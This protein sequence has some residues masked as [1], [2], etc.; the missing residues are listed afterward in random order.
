MR[1]KLL[2]GEYKN[3][4]EFCD[5]AWL[6]FEN[7]WLY[8][9]R[10]LRIYRMCTKLAQ[11]FGESIDPVLK[12]LGYCCGHQYVYLP[13]VMLCYGKQ[14]CCEIRPYSSY[15]YYN[16]PE[17]L[18]FNL[19][20]HQYTFCTNC[21]HSIK[22]ESIFVG[23]DPTQKLVEI[24][25][26]LFLRTENDIEE[27]E[28]MTNCI[29]CTR[30]WHQICAL[31]LDQIWS[32]GFICNTCIYQYNIKR[33]ENCYI[34]QKLTVTDLSSQ[35]EQRVN[36]YLFDKDCH[37][38]HVTIRV[39]AS[40]DKICKI[41]PQLKKYYPNQM[42][43]DS[44]PYR[45]KAIF[46]FQEIEGIDVVFF[47][48]YV[49]EYD[50]HCPAPNTSRVYISCLDTIHFF[51]PKLYRQDVYHE[52]L[53]LKFL[54]IPYFDGDLWPIIIEETIE[55]FDQE[56][57]R[58]KQEVETSQIIEDDNFNDSFELDD[59]TQI[60]SKRKSANTYENKT[61]KKTKNQVSNSTDLLSIIF[62]T[63]EKNKE[64]FFVIRLH[65]QTISY[66]TVND[67]D[68]LLLCNIMDTPN[69]FLNFVRHKNY[70]FSSL[71]SAKFSTMALLYELHTSTT[72]KF[73]YN[74]NRCLQKCDICYYCTVCEDLDLCEK[75]Y[76]M[77]LNH[78]H[79]MECLISSRIIMNQDN[80]QNSLN[81]N[82]ESIVSTQL[83]RQKTMQFCIDTL[84]HALNC[85][86]INCV[87]RGCLCYK[88]IIQ[89][90]KDCKEKN[91]QCYVCK[92]VIFLCWHH[93]KSC[94]NQNCQV[95]FCTNLKSIIEIQRA[96]SLQADRLLMETMMMQQETNI[97][98]TQ[99]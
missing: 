35:L 93:A 70:K 66:P 5:D 39:L 36:K 58:R 19:S 78:D 28:I 53:R 29:V 72:K 57:H 27:R 11:L 30:R 25:K 87:Y 17:P 44:Y 79:K 32:E 45:T 95:P 81:S 22:C 88:R 86:M 96:A 37:E 50:E 97:R 9:H 94:M 12:T 38:S 99:T 40:S 43:N 41:K 46:A 51:Q 63:M 52:I 76:N 49:Q 68:A 1:N 98:Q 34:A 20:S 75:F 18:R 33:K 31:H 80:E 89:H 23:D 2:H 8:N 55:K 73:I 54:D 13:K 77:Q 16:N 83:Q 3:P 82:N 67:T 65:H 61:L 14:K 91:R 26:K 47:G 59:P 10:T 24:S 60:S 69:A 4:L 74:C 62:S 15:Y 90:T 92:Q 85:Y 6:M 42:T 84:L 71:R 64:E 21:F 7:A 56:E 48:M